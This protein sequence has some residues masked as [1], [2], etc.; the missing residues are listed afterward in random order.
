MYAGRETIPRATP[1]STGMARHRRAQ[2]EGAGTRT[3]RR[4]EDSA[5]DQGAQ[6]L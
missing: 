3:Y 5:E 2:G 1:T 6:G 4:G